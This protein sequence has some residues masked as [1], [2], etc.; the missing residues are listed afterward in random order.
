[1]VVLCPKCRVRLKVNEA[2]ISSSGSRFKCPKCGAV[3]MV[4][5]PVDRL[6]KD[7]DTGKI[8]VAHSNPEI[9]QDIRSVISP[10]GC[11]IIAAADGIDAIVKAMK[12]YPFLTIME[13][14]L[15]KIYGFEV[16]KRLKSRP[17]TKGMKF[18]MIAS[19]YDKKKYRRNPVS[20]YG[21]DDYIEEH[22]IP[23]LLLD[24][25]VGLRG[26]APAGS[27]GIEAPRSPAEPQ[28]RKERTETVAREAVSPPDHISTD[29]KVEK[30]K[31]LART[32]INDI[33]LYNTAKVEDS[34]KNGN[35]Y[36]VFASE[37]REG[38]KLYENRVSPETR[39]VSD[40]FTE[41]IE[42]FLAAKA[43]SLL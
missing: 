18:I 8:L 36:A 20:L 29:K 23:E 42:N 43:D 12:D 17:E 28:V 25:T 26:H 24:K 41:A 38:R 30:A 27:P 35:F 33:Y 15:P 40:F 37:L 10:L 6:K 22:E 31:R 9:L 1:M 13:V 7:L 32:V 2:R 11:E 21:A 14:A 5:K 3:L 39:A 4:R 19:I 16:C 34:I